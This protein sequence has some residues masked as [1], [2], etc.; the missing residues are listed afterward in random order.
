MATYAVG[1]IQACYDEFRALLKTLRFNPDKDRLWLTGDLIGRGPKPLKTLRYI[2]DLGES[3]IVVLG[4]HDLNLLAHAE[5]FNKKQDKSLKPVL[6]A[7][8]RDEILNWLRHRPLIHHDPA[9]GYAM[10]HAGLAPQWDTVTAIQCAAEVE[11]SLRGDKYRKFLANMYGDKPSSWSNELKRMQRLRFITNC[12]TR[13]RYCH[14]DGSLAL[15]EKR[16]PELVDSDVIPWFALP[17]RQ[18]TDTTWLFGH[19]STLSHIYWPEHRVY[20]LDSGCIWGGALTA[21]CLE[22]QAVTTLPCPG[23]QRPE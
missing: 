12:L 4:N 5:G 23:Y 2:R 22:T 16:S 13:L 10:I 9:L 6:K 8:D 14:P 11:A 20:G 18:S 19:W 1:D 15:K 17:Q 7:K 3:A 21:L